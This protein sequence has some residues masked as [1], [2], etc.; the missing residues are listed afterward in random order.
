LPGAPIVAGGPYAHVSH[1]NYVVTMLETF[2]LP[3]CFGAFALAGI[4]GAVWAAV[5]VY[6]IRLEDAAL[7]ERRQI[8]VL[9]RDTD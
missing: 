9:R 6:K 2:L 5:L 7:A 3:A 1:P 4:M 8:R